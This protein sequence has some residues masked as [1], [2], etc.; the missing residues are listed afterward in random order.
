MGNA[1]DLAKKRISMK[2]VGGAEGA[3]HWRESQC[4]RAMDILA[5]MK[6]ALW[7]VWP[8][9]LRGCRRKTTLK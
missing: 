6:T 9:V 1:L 4:L 7:T 5:M 8:K 3:A 2:A